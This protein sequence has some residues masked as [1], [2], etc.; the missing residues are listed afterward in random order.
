MDV[1]LASLKSII[2]VPQDQKCN[3][4]LNLG[5]LSESFQVHSQ[6]MKGVSTSEVSGG[7]SPLGVPPNLCELGDVSCAV[8]TRLVTFEGYS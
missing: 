6:V 4:L 2:S 8:L 3:F 5:H 1:A 7:L